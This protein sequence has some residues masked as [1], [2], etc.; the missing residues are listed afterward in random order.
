MGTADGLITLH[1]AEQA[2]LAVEVLQN[3]GLGMVNRKTMLHC[4][5]C[6][7]L[8]GHQLTLAQVADTLGLRRIGDN[9]VA[10]SAVAADP[11]T[12]HTA[13]DDAVV[14]LNRDHMVDTDASC[15]QRLSLSLCAGH[16]VQDEA[17]LAIVLGDPLRD[18]VKNDIVGNEGTFV[19]DLLNFRSQRG[20]ICHGL[21]EH[22]PG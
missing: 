12:G 9:M 21:A 16:T 20:T 10:G 1:N 2:P 18:D 13:G 8:T 6:I 14:D 19:H 15:F 11:A 22:V 5:Q 3:L 7:I 4:F 17:A